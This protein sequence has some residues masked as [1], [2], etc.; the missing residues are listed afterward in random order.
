MM[1]EKEKEREIGIEIKYELE[2]K[3]KKIY[4]KNKCY[5]YEKRYIKYSCTL[6]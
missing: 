5:V 1:R 2:D 3:L 6:L 4:I